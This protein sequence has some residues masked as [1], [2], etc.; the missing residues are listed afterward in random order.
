MSVLP[1][2]MCNDFRTCLSTEYLYSFHVLCKNNTTFLLFII[3]AMFLFFFALFLFFLLLILWQ[4]VY[5]WYTTSRSLISS[6][7]LYIC[8]CKSDWLPMID[9]TVFKMIKLNQPSI[10]DVVDDNGGYGLC[11]K[12]G[13]PVASGDWWLVVTEQGSVECCYFLVGVPRCVNPSNRLNV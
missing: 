13:I 6:R 4:R 11:T 5:T 7:V 3:F 2:H 10:R 12:A 1:Y 8:T 9:W